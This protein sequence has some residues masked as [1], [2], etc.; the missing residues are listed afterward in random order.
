MHK[1]RLTSPGALLILATGLAGAILLLD[2]FFLRPY[3]AS[4][5]DAAFQEV[6]NR[7]ILGV[8]GDLKAEEGLLSSLCAAHRKNPGLASGLSGEG[9]RQKF[10][11][12][13]SAHLSQVPANVAWLVAADG[14]VLDVWSADALADGKGLTPA[15]VAEAMQ[16]QSL[17]AATASGLCRLAGQVAVF[18]QTEIVAD[19]AGKT[20]MGQF[21]LARFVDDAMLK[22]IGG[23]IEGYLMLVGGTS[24]PAGANASASEAI[25]PLSEDRVAAAWLATDSRGA[26]LGY[27]RAELPV[28]RVSAQASASRRIILIILSLSVG[29]VSL[30]IMGTHI[31]VAGPVVRLLRRL[32]QL[33]SG[34]G[35]VASLTTDLH[36]E[37][38]VLARRL[39]SAFERLARMSKTDTLTGLANR[40][41]FQEVLEAFYH[42]A[43]RYN[44]PLSII[45]LDVDYF[46]AVNDSAGH[47]AGDEVLQWVGA[48]IERA[49]RKADLPAR[50]GGD[51]FAV[52]LPET[53]C[54]DAEH[55][56]QRILQNISEQPVAIGALRLN[57]TASMGV[58]DLNCGE[59]D[60]PQQMFVQADRALYAA[61]EAGRNR[62]I[63]AHD[64]DAEGLLGDPAHPKVEVL[65]KKLAGL[66][67][68]FKDLFVNA[69]EEIVGVM[70]QRDTH[71]AAH[72]RK[73]RYC[74][75]LIA[76]EMGLPARVA[77]RLRVSA[78][79]HDIGLLSMPDSILLHP[80]PLDEDQ[81]R[82]VRRHPLLSVQIMERMEFL[83]HEIPAVRYHHERHDGR[84]Y[85]EGLSG[86]AI[87]LTARILSV[88]DSFGA[89]TSPR[90]FRDAKPF[91][92]AVEEIRRGAGSQFD[93]V[94]VD[95]FM[96]L[97]GRLGERL[98]Q[99]PPEEQDGKRPL[100][101][102][103]DEE[104][105]GSAA[106][107]PASSAT[108]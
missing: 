84:G 89:M 102:A 47:Q 25:W 82:A 74:S 94:V 71:L 4:Q 2:G 51:E 34:E 96:A 93:P 57:L 49:C 81:M 69:L 105:D 80:G 12:F 107:L 32:Q 1:L 98:L 95:A 20:R 77:Q 45:A 99:L 8:R 24:L 22:K 40:A 85:P 31:L 64:V 86:A 3:V 52:L 59:M 19:N 68:R 33:D 23:A 35:S 39:E 21:G 54:A 100:W 106:T 38:L 43:R 36:G 48:A 66:D 29:L 53:P 14:E 27:F 79:L 42:Q 44:R 73:V 101:R 76:Q 61:K 72:A 55:V 10:N 56:A 7:A 5:R 9:G 13:A 108:R 97:A 92:Q 26:A 41:H 63:L 50:M 90:A 62:V 67:N 103:E 17:R 88:A 87:P 58:A 15:M 28:G 65:Y 75:E 6:A 16:S 78:M 30:I 104:P 11:D 91:A 37:P 60:G 18:A 83:E 46:K 70:E